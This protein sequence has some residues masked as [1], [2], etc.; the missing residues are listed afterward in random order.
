[1]ID[2]LFG[3]DG[4]RAHVHARILSPEN[5]AK[6][7]RILGWIAQ[8]YNPTSMITIGRDTRASSIYLEQALIAGILSSGSN[9][10]TLGIVP[11]AVLAY[12]TANHNNNLGVMISASHNPYHDNG[13]KIFDGHGHKINR[14]MELL[15]NQYFLSDKDIPI[16]S[17]VGNII[18]HEYPYKAYLNGIEPY[19]A[20]HKSYKPN[21]VIDC[22]HGAAFKIAAQIF[23]H[24]ASEL[25]FIGCEPNGVNINHH[26]GSECLDNLIASVLKHKADLG[27][28][29]DGDAD[30]IALV[31]D[32]GEKIDGDALL[33]LMAIY[34]QQQH[35]LN[36]N[37]IIATTM[38]GPAL[39]KALSSYHIKV[40][41]SDVGDRYV[42]EKMR[43]HNLSFGGENSGHLL[44]FPESTTGDGIY[45][46]IQFIT[47]LAAQD[48]PLSMLKTIY[49][50]TPKLIAN[51]EV[52][53]KIALNHLPKTK[54]LIEN[55][56]KSLKG[57]GRVL[58]RYS[59]T[60][61]KARI[62]VEAENIHDCKNIMHDIINEFTLEK[63]SVNI[64]A[65][66]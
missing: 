38:S 19:F 23:P 39:D 52:T 3:T 37:T 48:K 63:E 64:M 30:R 15:I 18:N 43:D 10:Q 16:S 49:Q 53:H 28:A 4:I 11:T 8:K 29:F 13:L 44:F 60:E 57:S 41:R 34:R 27:I 33:T 1:M 20:K 9:C 42:A 32:K 35:K 2:D 21:L 40:L 12:L 55:A 65:S 56:N 14:D 59:G 5:V 26:F 24:L 6:L 47:M 51:I 17:K 58:F 45:S 66:L 61:N 22:A 7:G 31:D 36:N 25:T 62:L 46:A 50:P 54:T